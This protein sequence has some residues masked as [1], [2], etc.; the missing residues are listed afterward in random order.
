MRPDEKDYKHCLY[1]H[2]EVCSAPCVGHVTLEQY[3][4]QVEN[5]CEFLSGHCSEILQNLESAMVDASGAKDYERQTYVIELILKLEKEGMENL[6]GVMLRSFWLEHIKKYGELKLEQIEL[7][8]YRQFPHRRIG[9]CPKS[10]L[11]PTLSF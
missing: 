1:G 5:A 9:T 11:V 4:M 8:L 2:I 3:R 7:R 6:F 10:Q